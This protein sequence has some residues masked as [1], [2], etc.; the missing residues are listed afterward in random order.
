[1]PTDKPLPSHLEFELSR[2]LE[3]YY[4]I[5]TYLYREIH[6]HIKVE[7]EKKALERQPDFN[8]VAVF[9][10]ID[11]Q[12]Y[13]YL[14]FE[15][16]KRFMSK[17]NKDITKPEINA[18]IRRMDYDGDGKIAFNEFSQGITP[19][20]PGLEPDHMEFHLDKK[21]ELVKQYEINKKIQIKE[22]SLSP[23]RDFRN[24]Y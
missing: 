23:L 8:T 5:L 15:C 22:K 14:D 1:M 20:Y 19:E 12:R 11:F 9:T 24:I 13:G 6:Y 10:V 17:F 16:L 4:I 7:I 21:E 18:I 2:L 3:K